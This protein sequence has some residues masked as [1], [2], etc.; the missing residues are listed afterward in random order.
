MIKRHNNHNQ[1][2]INHNF[3]LSSAIPLHSKQ[4]GIA[5]H[6]SLYI[7]DTW[8]KSNLGYDKMWSILIEDDTFSTRGLHLPEIS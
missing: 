1:G 6:P 7:V 2:E 4:W 3:D 5:H 8:L